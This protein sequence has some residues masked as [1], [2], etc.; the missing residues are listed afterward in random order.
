MLF[1]LSYNLT[2]KVLPDKAVGH[3][4][5]HAVKSFPSDKVIEPID[6]PMV[7][8][9]VVGV[10]TGAVSE[11]VVRSY[12]ALVTNMS[13]VEEIV[14]FVYCT[15]AGAEITNFASALN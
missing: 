5:N 14:I 8:T 13:S 3:M 9:L 6:I 4:I 7:L 2:V 12:L 10:I 1:S 15:P 11:S